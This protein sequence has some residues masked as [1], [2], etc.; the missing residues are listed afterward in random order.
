MFLGRRSAQAEY[1]DLPGRSASDISSDFRDLD[2]INRFFQFARPFQEKLPVWL[3]AERCRELNILDVGAGTGLLA[4][5]LSRWAAKR[6]WKWN[7]T[8]LDANSLA[9]PSDATAARVVGSALKLPFADNRFDLVI[10]SQMTHHLT[11]DEAAMHLREA[12]RVTRD[13]VM[14]SDMHRN[15][16][17]HAVLWLS[18]LLLGI[19]RS[20]RSDALVSVQRGFRCGEFRRLA[21]GANLGNVRVKLYYGARILLF[22]RKAGE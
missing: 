3:G 17:L 2:R 12:W 11:D 8:N 5:T 7:F 13:A 6:D 20:V 19:G 1:F 4:Q 15:L 9:P 21:E 22:A 18:T 10:A 16:G 14:I